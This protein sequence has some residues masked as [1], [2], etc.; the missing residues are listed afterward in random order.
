MKTEQ[1][2]V[3]A[4]INLA[5]VTDWHDRLQDFSLKD[6]IQERLIKNTKI[7][8]GNNQFANEGP[9]FTKVFEERLYWSHNGK[10]ILAFT[11]FAH[12]IPQS[13]N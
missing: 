2:I 3:L 10:F 9:K 7:K 5:Q 12:L 4:S 1:Y 6:G 13:T 8:K 11:V